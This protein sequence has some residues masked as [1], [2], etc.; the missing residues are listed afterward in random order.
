MTPELEHDPGRQRILE[1]LDRHDVSYVVIGGVAAQ[2][3]G[4]PDVTQD[5]YV[6][7]ARDPHP[8]GRCP[9]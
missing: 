5:I 1:S 8:P 9:D 4:W 6:T 2:S 3:R 7:P